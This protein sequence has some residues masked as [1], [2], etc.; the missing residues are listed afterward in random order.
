MGKTKRGL[1]SALVAAFMAV[2]AVGVAQAQ[3]NFPDKPIRLIVPLA[4]GGGGDIVARQLAAG[5]SEI[6]G[7]P[8]IVDNK[9][10][11]ST[12]I[13]T[14]EAAKAAPDGYTLVMATSS[15]VINPSVRQLPFDAVKGF[16][17][18]SLIATTPAILVVPPNFPA[19]TV[20]EVIALAKA[21]PGEFTFG[22]SGIASSPHLSGELFNMMAGTDIR[23]VPYKGMGPA[24]NDLVGGHVT[25]VFSSPVSAIPLV[26]SGKLKAIAASSPKRAKAFPDMPTIAETLPGYQSQIFYVILAPKGTPKPVLDKL[27][28]AFTKVATSADFTEK[29]LATGGEVV[30]GSPA[31][32]LAFIAAE[33][34]GYESIIKKAK[35]EVK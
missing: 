4:A 31:E 29:M 2:G 9:P 28:Q 12:I 25:M 20:Q 11:G 32:A 8:M 33:V 30:A 6:L 22:S 13:G 21:K 23:H 26:K 5:A 34:A 3:A 10:G 17:G 16:E 27:N 19:N 1:G 7:Q 14:A 18:V 15:H 35:I 24:L